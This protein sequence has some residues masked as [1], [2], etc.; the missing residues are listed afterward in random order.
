MYTFPIESLY[1]TDTVLNNKSAEQRAGR[2]AASLEVSTPKIIPIVTFLYLWR[3]FSQDI[4]PSL[5]LSGPPAERKASSSPPGRW[6][7]FS[8]NLSAPSW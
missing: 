7:V 4:P 5:S 8:G 1:L 2:L 6:R 3:P